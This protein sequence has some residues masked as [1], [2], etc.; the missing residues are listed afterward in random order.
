MSSSIISGDSSINTDESTNGNSYDDGNNSN[1]ATTK[2]ITPPPI[3]YSS[4][5]NKSSSIS[6]PSISISSSQSSSSMSNTICCTIHPSIQLKRRRRC[7]TTNNNDKSNDKSN[8]KEDNEECWIQLIKECPLCTADDNDSVWS[9]RTTGSYLSRS[10]KSSGSSSRNTTLRSSPKSSSSNDKK[11]IYNSAP[12]NTPSPPPT[13]PRQLL[14]RLSPSTTNNTTNS[15]SKECIPSKFKESKDNGE[16]DNKED[17]SQIEQQSLKNNKD[18]SQDTQNDN[19]MEGD[20]YSFPSLP[21]TQEDYND[22][23][24]TAATATSN[25]SSSSMNERTSSIKQMI[26]HRKMKLE[27][28]KL[29]RSSNSS[30]STGRLPPSQRYMN[31]KVSIEEEDSL[32]EDQEQVVLVSSSVKSSQRSLHSEST[33]CI[34]NST[35]ARTMRKDHASAKDT[36]V[37]TTTSSSDDD[38]TK[39]SSSNNNSN[40]NN[41]MLETSFYSNVSHSCG[42]PQKDK[43]TLLPVLPNNQQEVVSNQKKLSRC[44]SDSTLSSST[45]STVK[46][47]DKQHQQQQQQQQQQSYYNK[48]IL[49]ISYDSFVDE[50]VRQFFNYH[51][52]TA[53]DEVSCDMKE[54][55]KEKEEEDCRSDMK[56]EEKDNTATKEEEQVSCITLDISNRSSDKEKNDHFDTTTTTLK[57]QQVDSKKKSQQQSQTHSQQ[58]HKVKRKAKSKDDLLN[59]ATYDIWGS[60]SNNCMEVSQATTVTTT[61]DDV[62]ADD[63]KELIQLSNKLYSLVYPRRTNTMENKNPRHPSVKQDTSSKMS[64]SNK[65]DINNDLQSMNIEEEVEE[66]VSM[67]VSPTLSSIHDNNTRKEDADDDSYDNDND[68]YSISEESLLGEEPPGYTSVNNKLKKYD[69]YNN[70]VSSSSYTQD[71]PPGD[72]MSTDSDYYYTRSSPGVSTTSSSDSYSLGFDDYA[73]NNQPTGGVSHYSMECSSDESRSRSSHP[74]E[75]RRE[76]SRDNHPNNPSILRNSISSKSRTSSTSKETSRTDTS[77]RSNST[78]SSSISKSKSSSKTNGSSTVRTQ[79]S[80]KTFC[81]YDARTGRCI[82]HPHIQLRRKRRLGGFKK[83]QWKIISMNCTECAFEEV[84]RLRARAL[85]KQQQQLKPCSSSVGQK[86]QYTSATE[87]SSRYTTSSSDDSQ[88]RD[89]RIP[90]GILKKH[91]SGYHYIDDSSTAN[92]SSISLPSIS[93]T[94]SYSTASSTSTPVSFPPRGILRKPNKHVVYD[95]ESSFLSG[96][97]ELSGLSE[98]CYSDSTGSSSCVSSGKCHFSFQNVVHMICIR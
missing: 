23:T 88:S 63:N 46:R 31:S 98:S 72:N 32:G 8:I 40:N 12:V 13:A 81:H 94:Q 27:E 78:G 19:N 82:H 54:D 39:P 6:S 61:T 25:N 50:S 83:G 17:L 85:K 67:N 15:N 43:L 45:V 21:F 7:R 92:G 26:Q 65:N 70:E 4:P 42:S 29:R 66:G 24:T 1:K 79:E 44:H 38:D 95:N 76:R 20:R 84:Q 77:R 3:Y 35:T 60:S 28:L 87:S 36:N 89:R 9:G 64:M 55:M 11:Q 53:N 62:A 10:S 93:E 91:P 90:K 59:T 86:S 69:D 96:S 97:T 56:E 16:Y 33:K 68:G 41:N 14:R 75:R 49:D 2:Q 30:N 18:Y 52:S 57:Q 74:D 34:S 37:D 51:T 80:V 5:S 22:T 47:D 73:T 48:S 71:D 58:K